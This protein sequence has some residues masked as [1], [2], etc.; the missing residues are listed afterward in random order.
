MEA[1]CTSE[2]AATIPTY[3]ECEEP[4]VVTAKNESS[5]VQNQVKN[6]KAVHVIGRGGP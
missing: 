5:S 6:I 1:A 4:S 2:M 3:T